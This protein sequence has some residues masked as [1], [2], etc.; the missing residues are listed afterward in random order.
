MPKLNF[1]YAKLG[2]IAGVATGFL[3]KTISGLVSKIPG[4]SLDLQS[5]S[6]STSG[7]GGVVNTG[8]SSYAQKL[9]G[10][11]PV[12]LQIPELLWTAVGG[13]LFMMLGAYVV[14]L[15]KINFAKSK[16]GKLATIM[17]IAGIVSGWILSMSIGIPA[18]SG[19]IIMV[20][21]A[22]I[23]SWI[24]IQVDKAAKTKLIP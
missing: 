20:V 12:S 8:L 3:L 10:L 4:V 7:L 21:D 24:L 23:L 9:F 1:A 13:A 19:I 18:F 14:E 2:A 5:V 17:V 22:L 16:A 6:I 15:A 11:V